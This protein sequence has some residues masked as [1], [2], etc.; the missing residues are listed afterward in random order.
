M[1]GPDD[2]AISA[3]SKKVCYTMNAD[4]TP[5]TS[6]N[7]DLFVVPIAGGESIKI[8]SATQEPT[9]ARKYSPDGKWLAYIR[10]ARAGYEEATAGVY[11]CWT[12]PPARST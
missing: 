11:P 7:S 10:Q 12:A 3:D 6:T 9:P 2:Y 5:A 4:P 1:G 8:T